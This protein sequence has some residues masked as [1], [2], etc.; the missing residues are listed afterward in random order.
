MPGV[1]TAKLA[2]CL[3]STALFAIYIIACIL[4]QCTMPLHLITALN[5]SRLTVRPVGEPDLPALLLINGHDAVT[6]HLPYATWQSDADA[7]AWLARMQGLAT[8]GTAQ[9]LVV[10]HTASRTVVGAVL[11]F[12]YDEGS[13]RAELGYVLGRP[14]WRQGFAQE[15][16]LAVCQHAFACMG[17]RRIEAE[18]NPAN[19]ASN[20]LLQSLGF[21]REG[22]MRQRWTAKGVT[23]DTALY[24]C[25]ANDLLGANRVGGA[26]GVSEAA[27][28]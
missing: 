26:G 4:P 14:H 27:A 19:T 21:V 7:Q 25:L 22:L 11:I 10:V 24:G 18:V 5:T 28:A 6:Q 23:Y 1:L 20:A 17:I 9:Q 2:L 3:T 13:A 16:I 15:A 8:S 12:K